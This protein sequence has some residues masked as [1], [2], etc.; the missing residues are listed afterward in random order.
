[1]QTHPTLIVRPAS[2][3]TPFTEWL[4]DGQAGRS[5]AADILLSLSALPGAQN[6]CLLLPANW[7]TCCQFSLPPGSTTPPQQAIA[8][9]VEEQL[10]SNSE[11]LHWTIAGRQDDICYV[12]G[13][14]KEKLKQLLDT[15]RQAGLTITAV[16]PDGCYLPLSE[17]RW[18]ALPLENGWLVRHAEFSWSYMT[19]AI[20]KQLTQR[21]S[22][23]APLI[24]EDMQPL[25]SYSQQFTTPPLNLLHSEFGVVK[26]A[27]PVSAAW[28]KRIAGFTAAAILMYLGVQGAIIWGLHQEQ[29][30]Q[31]LALQENWQR[32]FPGDKQQGN[33]RFFFRQKV[34][35]FSPDPLTRLRQLEKSL[36][37]V[38]GIELGHFAADKETGTLTL[39]V[40]A[41]DAATIEQL[42]AHSGNTL[43][44][45]LSSPATNNIYSLQG[46]G[47]Q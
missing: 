11:A 28:R 38:P 9:Q 2:E 17:D 32:Y 39:T 12:L 21:F 1:M 10:I 30:T 4:S 31:R 42:I 45:K 37:A 26:P 36:K 40:R 47:L 15:W 25:L 3:G 34:K 46:G 22:P 23:E 5:D 41:A 20:F 16:V 35:R 24:C 18:S 43:A 6:V 7:L 27:Y 19:H 8:W 29:S 33:Y 44:L 13:V 14:D